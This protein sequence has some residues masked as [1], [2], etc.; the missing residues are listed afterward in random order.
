MKKFSATL[1]L[2]SIFLSGTVWAGNGFLDNSFMLKK[3]ELKG[4]SMRNASHRLAEDGWAFGE[5][6]IVLSL[7]YGAGSGGLLKAVLKAYEDS[8]GYNFTSFGPIHFRGELGLSEKVGIVLSVNY[9]SWRANWTHTG[10]GLAAT[11]YQDELKRTVTSILG[12]FNFHFGTT[13]KLDAYWGIGAGYRMPKYT[14]T[15]TEPGYDFTVPG[16]SHF[17]LETTLGVRYYLMPGFGLYGELGLAQSLV[18]G[19][20]VVAF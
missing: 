6:K 14:F 5:G 12:R 4:V 17:G 8:A 16:I 11:V 3:Q 7:G 10:S 2:F 15:S 9:N 18:Q 1:M 20:I 13:E 19:G